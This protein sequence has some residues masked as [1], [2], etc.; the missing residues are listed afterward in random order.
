MPN[1]DDLIGQR[2][3]TI[4]KYSINI[5][6]LMGE[7]REGEPMAGFRRVSP[8]PNHKIAVLLAVIQRVKNPGS[9]HVQISQSL[10]TR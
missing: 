2:L 3:V 8:R 5:Y 9:P 4:G 10:R 7:G 6:Y 1:N